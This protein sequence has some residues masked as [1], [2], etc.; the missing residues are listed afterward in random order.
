MEKVNHNPNEYYHG[1]KTEISDGYLRPQK[2]FNSVQDSV[3]EGAFV[4]SDINHAKFFAINSCICGNGHTKQEGKKIYLERLSPHI[5][6]H[7]YVYKAYETKENP[8]IHDEG[9]EYYSTKPIKIAGFEKFNTAEEI[10]NLGYEVYVLDKPLE[11]VSN[12]K[13]GNN[14]AVRLEMEK[15]IKEHRYHQVDIGKTIEQQSKNMF[16]NIFNKFIQKNFL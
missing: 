10:K 5:K 7:F 15:A 16:C 13:K 8:F 3:C 14:F 4:T 12:M 11:N 2:A 1:S 6:T 9:T